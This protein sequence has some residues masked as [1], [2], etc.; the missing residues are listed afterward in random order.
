V[1]D[2]TISALF[3]ELYTDFLNEA[4]TKGER[5]L[6]AHYTSIQ[7]LEKI[8][9]NEEIWLSNPLFMNDLGEMKFGFNAGL[10]RF[11]SNPII[12]EACGSDERAAEVRRGYLYYYQQYDK[13]HA[14]NVYVFCASKHEPS[15]Y[16]GRLSM[17]RAYGGNGAGVSIVFNTASISALAES[18]L[19]IAKV[20]YA[21]TEEC[22]E[23]IDQ[24]IQQW[25][26]IVASY[27]IPTDKLYL[28]V[29][30]LFYFIE[31]FALTTKHKGFAE[32]EEWRL[33]YMPDRDTKKLLTDR[34]DYTVTGRGVEPKLKLKIAPSPGIA[35]SPLSLA[36]L[37]DRIILG[38]SVSSP[39]ARNSACR[40]L[41]KLGKMEFV[42]KVFSSSIP[43]RPT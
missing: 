12:D 22:N 43:L 3:G 39:L 42:D 38:P 18:P 36:S 7:V 28:A 23:Y 41:E 40:M 11:A 26:R 27:S 29:Y 10:N 33:I 24:K 35:D 31:L 4:W 2:E 5:P 34:F 15:D 8:F 13:E 25:S 30:Q 16:D 9:C 20:R 6:L 19:S 17:W 21:S 32:E 1:T 14:L 37:L